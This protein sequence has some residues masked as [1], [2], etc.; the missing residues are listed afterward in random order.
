LF[1]IFKKRGGDMMEEFR[2]GNEEKILL[3]TVTDEDYKV[4][5]NNRVVIT[6]HRCIFFR[7]YE[8]HHRAKAINS[9]TGKLEEIKPE[10]RIEQ[11][12]KLNNIKE[13]FA[14]YFKENVCIKFKLTNGQTAIFPIFSYLDRE[15]SSALDVLTQTAFSGSGS[16]ML[17]MMDDMFL[18]NRLVS[19]INKLIK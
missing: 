15:L 12:I 10:F 6:N 17:M 1:I 18:V 11:E 7:V 8:V 13:T 19:Y 14:H 9:A 2:L 4:R 16:L 3:D 5:L